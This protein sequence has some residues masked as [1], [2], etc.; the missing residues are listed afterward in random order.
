MDAQHNNTNHALN[1]TEIAKPVNT[2]RMTKEEA[3]QLSD[4]ELLQMIEKATGHT[5]SDFQEFM[6]CTFSYTTLTNILKNR[7]YENGWHKTSEGSSPLHNPVTIILEKSDE[8]L[9]RPGYSVPVSIA[10]EWKSFN[11]NNPHKSVALGY[12]LQ[13]FMEDQRS[14]KIK[15]E[16]KFE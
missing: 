5:G 10:D 15:L 6:S 12:A 14:G 2:H 1:D 8:K 3:L 16:V 11:R 13:R 7:G 4:T 9:V